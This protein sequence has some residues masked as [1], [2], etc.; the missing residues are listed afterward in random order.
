MSIKFSFYAKEILKCKQP[1]L[2]FKPQSAVGCIWENGLNLN[3][4]CPSQ[5]EL[6]D[7]L[8]EIKWYP[9]VPAEFNNRD[10][11]I[12]IFSVYNNVE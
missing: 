7:G 4:Y 12:K 3:I 1:E 2:L 9:A 10:F 6:E 8:L 11:Y 5:S